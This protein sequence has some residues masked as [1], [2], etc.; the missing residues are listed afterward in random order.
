VT[1]YIATALFSA[2]ILGLLFL[3]RDRKSRPSAAIWI[4]VIWIFL[5]GSRQVSQWLAGGVE[6]VD[7]PDQY[8]EGSPL[9][10]MI[11]AGLMTA[12]LSVLVT[13][14]RRTALAIASNTPLVLFFLYCA[15][16]IVWAD[17]PFVAFKRWT[18]ALG[19]I[20]MVL[21][22]LTDPDPIAA[23]RR[24]FA[25]VSFLL[26]PLSV[27]LIK[28]YPELG[29]SYDRW[30]GTAFYNGAAVGKNS[31][32]AVCLICGLSSLWLVFEALRN[33]TCRKR[34]LMAHGS[35]LAMTMWLFLKANSATSLSCFLVGAS[36][37]SFLALFKK[38]SAIVHFAVAVMVAAG[39]S[40]VIMPA[41]STYI[42]ET[43]GRDATLTGR[44][45]LWA[46]VLNLQPNPLLG[47]GFESFWLGERAE[48]LWSK[49]WWHPN[50]AHNGYIEMY[51]NL[52]WIGIGLLALLLASG[53]RN[54]FAAMKRHNETGTI[55]LAIM[56]AAAVYN[57]TEAAVKVVHPVWVYLLLAV[58]AVPAVADM[59]SPVAS[60]E[61][62]SVAPAGD[63]YAAAMAYRDMHPPGV[64]GT[65]WYN[66]RS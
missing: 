20:T 29:R 40:A 54:A 25:R 64:R 55:M 18:K 36:L 10:R 3:D 9:D 45:E 30:V 4:P 61:K 1:R 37:L 49:Y 22:V 23:I 2:G 33:P 21:V 6:F 48:Y 65:A 24:L 31:L 41:A 38:H 11:L 13:R 34:Q 15:I 12:G 60:R 26:V 16:S 43:L 27:L 42:L 7:S 35:I 53:Y 62:G 19:N 52:G 57:F 47:S 50:Q 5:G 46:E 44:T 32:G 8:L 17:Y 59:T 51:L 66:R 39:L 58:S 63:D 14:G 28:Y 56:L